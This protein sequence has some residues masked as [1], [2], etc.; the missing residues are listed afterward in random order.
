MKIAVL[1]TSNSVL[2]SGYFETYKAIEYPNQVDLFAIGGTVVSF[3]AFALEYFQIL[4]NYDVIIT[5]FSTND[6]HRYEK[7]IVSTEYLYEYIYDVFAAIRQAGKPH[8]NLLFGHPKTPKDCPVY[9]IYRE[10]GSLFQTCSIEVHEIITAANTA[11]I[12]QDEDHYKSTVAKPVA[13]CILNHRKKLTEQK[14]KSAAGNTGFLPVREF[15]VKTLEQILPTRLK[16]TSLLTLPVSDIAHQTPIPQSSRMRIEG[17]FYRATPFIGAVSLYADPKLHVCSLFRAA[18]GF[19]YHYLPQKFCSGNSEIF[20]INHTG[21]AYNEK[22]FEI[23]GITLSISH[24]GRTY[25]PAAKQNI[26]TGCTVKICDYQ[27]DLALYNTI[28]ALTISD[29]TA[30]NFVHSES[31]PLLLFCAAEIQENPQ[32]ACF[33]YEKAC[34]LAKFSNPFFLQKYLEKLLELKDWSKLNKILARLPKFPAPHLNLSLC[35]IF[36]EQK[37]YGEALANAASA[38]HTQPDSLPALF[39]F[40]SVL[41]QTEKFKEA[42]ALLSKC[43]TINNENMAYYNSLLY[44][45]IKLNAAEQ[46]QPLLQQI[47]EYVRQCAAI[48]YR[49][50]FS[51]LKQSMSLLT[52]ENSGNFYPFVQYMQQNNFVLEP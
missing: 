6:A 42:A 34:T 50:D 29:S 22:P 25:P 33:L 8:I 16:G 17:I 46:I 1:G 3:A 43:I 26:N 19:F 39:A 12:W 37:Q 21:T 35:R 47:E 41:I 28:G 23:V 52:K 24:E 2:T 48:Q 13:C 14:T 32:S 10:L 15:K 20:L 40:S 45:L 11:N 38:L 36:A 7:K 4:K 9:A 31:A 5:E 44:C 49:L 51:V 27:E 18:S 30:D